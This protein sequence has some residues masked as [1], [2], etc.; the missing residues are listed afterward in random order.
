MHIRGT[1]LS[2]TTSSPWSTSNFQWNLLLHLII[3]GSSSTWSAEWNK[4][5]SE[6]LYWL[7]HTWLGKSHLNAWLFKSLFSTLCVCVCVCWGLHT[8]SAMWLCL[9]LFIVSYCRKEKWHTFTLQEDL[10]QQCSYSPLLHWAAHR[11]DI[12]SPQVSFMNI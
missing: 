7:A 11:F 10:S 12:S 6:G 1:S 5:E 3:T 2:Y 8:A 9:N 4:V